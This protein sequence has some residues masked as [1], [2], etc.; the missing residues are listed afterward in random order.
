VCCCVDTQTT[1][2]IS[3]TT[4][5]TSIPTITTTLTTI[6]TTTTTTIPIETDCHQKCQDWYG[7]TGVCRD[8]RCNAG[9]RFNSRQ[10]CTGGQVCCCV[11]EEV[12][13]I[14]FDSL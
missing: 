9:E 5:S 3:T 2:T 7:R 10:D 4:T 11:K 8:K 13:W 1:T 6:P 14:I 12:G